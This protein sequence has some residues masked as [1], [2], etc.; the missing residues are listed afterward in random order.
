M[1]LSTRK[2]LKSNHIATTKK[3]MPRPADISKRKEDKVS[4]SESI[5]SVGSQDEPVP[6]E[7]T[8]S[9]PIQRRKS[10]RRN[11]FISSLMSRSK[12]LYIY[13]FYHN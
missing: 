2:N 11:S 8:S 13:I 6:E 3:V 1:A 12:V 5:P 10:D 9:S 7:D 4:V